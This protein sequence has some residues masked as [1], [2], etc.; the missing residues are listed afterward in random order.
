MSVK[1]TSGRGRL[2]EEGQQYRVRLQVDGRDIPLKEFLHDMLGG[3]V[4]GLM[5]GLR[6]VD[7]AQIIRIEAERLEGDSSSS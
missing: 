4:T 2:A 6:D 7:G 3:A 5:S 1:S